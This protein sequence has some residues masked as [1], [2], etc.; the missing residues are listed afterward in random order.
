MRVGQKVRFKSDHSLEVIVTKLRGSQFE[1]YVVNDVIR[2][3]DNNLS[4]DFKAREFF[5]D[6]GQCVFNVV[7]FEKGDILQHSNGDVY[8]YVSELYNTPEVSKVN[9]LWSFNNHWTY[10]E[11]STTE[12]DKLAHIVT[13]WSV[14]D[15]VKNKH[16]GDIMEVTSVGG[17]SSDLKVIHQVEATIMKTIF[18][19]QY[20][21]YIKI[22]KQPNVG[23]FK[24]GDILTYSDEDNGKLYLEY[25]RHDF[26]SGY[27]FDAKVLVNSMGE[28][29]EDKV[30]SVSGG[31]T[32][33]AF[34][35]APED[36]N[37]TKPYVPEVGDLFNIGIG[38]ADI[39]MCRSKTD[40]VIEAVRVY[41][42]I[43]KFNT[44]HS[45]KIR[46]YN[47]EKVIKHAGY[48]TQK[49]KAGKFAMR[50][51]DKSVVLITG[52]DD[53]YDTFSGYFI[54]GPDTGKYYMTLTKD[55]FIRM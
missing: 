12:T 23:K 51:E 24:K 55:E 29:V 48:N 6:F 3:E 21:D 34:E 22:E 11:P 13:P 52:H 32:Y 40:E 14:G 26:G 35:K 38:L 53:H 28:V 5:H 2:T 47:F 15:W 17:F 37:K 27:S 10:L 8:L 25:I 45:R 46:Y 44:V 19:K 39:Y 42:E 33:E 1:G 49:F 30:G 31:W 16:T 9:L 4:K 36:W 20:P 54:T 41:P 43:S 50:L 7:P 18:F